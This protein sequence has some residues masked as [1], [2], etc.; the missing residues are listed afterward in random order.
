MKSS[1]SS[2]STGLLS[3]WQ[4]L[5]GH[6]PPLSANPC[7][8]PVMA[9]R[10]ET[11]SGPSAFGKALLESIAAAQRRIFISAL[12]L[13]ND[14]A[15]REILDAIHA[16]KNA[17]PGLETALF[18]DWHR[19]QR[20]LIGKGHSQGNIALY[21]AKARKTGRELPVYGIPVQK[22]EL[23]GVLHLKGMVIDDDVF[24]SG[25]SINN[26]YLQWKENYRL[27]RYHRIHSPK[28]ADSMARLM[29][30]VLCGNP[31]VCPID[32]P[33][34]PATVELRGKITRFR[35]LLS[36][37]HYQF[38]REG[39][40]PGHVYITP[41]LGIGARRNELNASI[42]H[43]I[44]QAERRLLLFTPY[45][46]LPGPILREVARKI[47]TGCHVVIVI[48]DK[49]ANDFYIPPDQPFKAIGA[50][51]Y[52][53]EA[54][55]RRFCETHQSAMDHGQLD[56]LLWRH[57]ANTFHVKGLLADDNYLLLTGHNLN[58]RAWRL[59]LE[60]GL[61]IHD[62]QKLLAV[63]NQAEFRRIAEHAKRVSRYDEIETV[64]AYPPP[65]QRL[66]RRIARVRIDRLLNQIL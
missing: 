58:P 52:L 64:D 5:S 12:Y 17:R 21:K 44:R 4:R 46:N 65:V 59:D 20:G 19:A 3:V 63:Q 1:S 14:E 28:L 49:S 50:I 29:S 51:P 9:S 39:L 56:V 22:S 40:T 60:N 54:N 55:L 33:K 16:A 53:Y 13:E 26:V 36:A 25:A 48:G 15:G 62:P 7:G 11:L 8:I 37:A 35:R 66:I 45:F 61:L 43:L 30:D 32:A 27:D 41:L 38:E 23:M 6:T 57:G 31:A 2:H 34:T 18:V 10:V 42:V 47:Q 24:Y